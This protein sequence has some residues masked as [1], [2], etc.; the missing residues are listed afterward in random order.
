MHDEHEWCVSLSNGDEG[1]VSAD[2]WQVTSNGD[3]LFINGPYDREPFYVR[4]FAAGTWKE[5]W[6]Y[7]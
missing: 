3:L 2:G 1:R 6:L 7:A 4:A 5:V